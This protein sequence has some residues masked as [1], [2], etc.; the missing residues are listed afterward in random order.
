M[1]TLW[2]LPL[3]AWAVETGRINLGTCSMKMAFGLPCWSCGATRGTIRLLHGDVVEA[4]TFQPMMMSL[5]MILFTWGAISLVTFWRGKRVK[6]ELTRVERWLFG[7]SLLVVPL[8]NWAYLI[9]A[10]I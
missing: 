7:A 9:N 10:G 5:Y 8:T 4:F 6:L 2:F 3:G 1:S